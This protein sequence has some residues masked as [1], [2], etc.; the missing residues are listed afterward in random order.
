MLVEG[1][2]W[3]STGP[4]FAGTGQYRFEKLLAQNQPSRQGSETRRRE[5]IA[6]RVVDAL[7]QRLPHS[8]IRL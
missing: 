2:G 8:F 7:D 4:R 1:I 6:S 5:A 3:R